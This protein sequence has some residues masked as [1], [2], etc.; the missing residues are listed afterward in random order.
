MIRV[1]PFLFLFLLLLVGCK[2]NLDNLLSD[3]DS[4]VITA[5]TPSQAN[6]G[7]QNVNGL[8]TG[9]NFKGIVAVDLGSGVQILSTVV[10]SSTEIAVKFNVNA[11]AP[12]GPRTIR[13]ST[14]GGIAQSSTAFS[15]KATAA[16][17]A[18]FTVDPPKGGKT[19]LFHFNASGSDDSDGH[20]TSYAWDFGDGKT[21]TGKIIDHQYNVVGNFSVTLTVTDNE[22]SQSSAAKNIQVENIKPPIARYTVEPPAG[23]VDTVFRFD[24]SISEDQDGRIVRYEWDFKDGT[25]LEG[26]T[27]HHQFARSD[28]FNVKLTVFDSDGLQDFFEREVQVRGVPPVAKIEISPNS[29]DTNTTFRFDGSGSDDPDGNI[30]SY[31]WKFA[32]GSRFTEKTFERKFPENGNYSVTLTVEDNDGMQ[33]STSADVDVGDGG[34]PPPPPPGD[35]EECRT[36]AKNNGLIFGTVVGVDGLNA[37]VRLPAGSTCANSFYMCGDMR[38]ANPEQFRGIIKKMVD[39]G[40]GT[41]SVFNDCPFKWPPDIGEEVFLYYKTCSENFCPK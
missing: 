8:I 18:S 11:D 4:P 15:I 5:M 30:V 25:I 19:T 21:G 40:N 17:Q 33:D 32:G 3:K 22:S 6:R 26:K 7:Q 37:I 29:G 38:R 2:E 34:P 9:T 28:E 13:V 41:F 20:I 1:I 23:S 12:S 35:G 39:L 16:P 24:G 27:V 31:E 36:P 10:N 14:L